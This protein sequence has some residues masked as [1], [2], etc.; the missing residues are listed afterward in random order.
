MY[1]LDSIYYIYVLFVSGEN[2]ACLMDSTGH[3]E[4]AQGQEHLSSVSEA[5]L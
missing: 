4:T 5:L 3:V 1:Y 2:P